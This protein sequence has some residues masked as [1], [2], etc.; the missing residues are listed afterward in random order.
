MKLHTTPYVYVNMEDTTW[1]RGDTKFLFKCWNIFQILAV[2][3][4]ML[5]YL[6]EKTKVWTW[7][8]RLTVSCLFV[9]QATTG[10]IFLKK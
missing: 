5:Y 2:Q 10:A 6:L 4:K 8:Y 1:S 3:Q 7:L 9:A